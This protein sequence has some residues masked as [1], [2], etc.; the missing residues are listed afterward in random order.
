MSLLSTGI[1]LPR[2]AFRRPARSLVRARRAVGP[3]TS[4]NTLS[5]KRDGL[6]N[7]LPMI[8]YYLNPARRGSNRAMTPQHGTLRLWRLRCY[9]Q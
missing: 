4:P 7:L 3:R 9:L 1:D 6:F 5:T 2:T 8:F